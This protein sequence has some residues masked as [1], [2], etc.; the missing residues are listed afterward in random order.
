MAKN[1]KMA[2]K[3]H[4]MF[5]SKAFKT[6]PILEFYNWKYTIWH[7]ACKPFKTIEVSSG[8]ANDESIK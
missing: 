6:K 3:Y 4:K 8:C 5:H 7:P 1:T 2:E